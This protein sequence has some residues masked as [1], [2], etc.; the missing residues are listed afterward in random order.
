MRRSI[1]GGNAEIDAQ[2]KAG[3]NDYWVQEKRNE[4]VKAEAYAGDIAGRAATRAIG[5]FTEIHTPALGDLETIRAAHQQF[6]AGCREGRMDAETATELFLEL[7]TDLQAVEN[8]LN[9]AAVY[10]SIAERAEDDP[11]AYFDNLA[12]T[13]PSVGG[14]EFSF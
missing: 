8:R 12:E 10:I 3:K 11:V 13:Y 4:I 6:I 1:G 14:Y 7:G 2:A 5:K 9:Q